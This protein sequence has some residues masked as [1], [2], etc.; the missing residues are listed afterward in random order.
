[1]GVLKESKKQATY[2]DDTG[3]LSHFTTKNAILCIACTMS[4]IIAII[5]AAL[6]DTWLL[7]FID[8]VISPLCLYL[9]THTW[10][11]YYIKLC[12]CCMRKISVWL[13]VTNDIVN[14]H[15]QY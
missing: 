9:M 10:D 8:A 2:T 13:C 14:K 1:M 7:M 12:S 5:Y 6:A 3:E 15:V 11:H 4:T